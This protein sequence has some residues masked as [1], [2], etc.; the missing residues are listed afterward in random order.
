MYMFFLEEFIILITTLMTILT[1]F[2]ENL[3]LVFSESN[4]FEV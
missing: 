4:D 2:V 3:Y 1:D